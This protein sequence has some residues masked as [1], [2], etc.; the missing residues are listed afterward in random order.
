MRASIASAD[1]RS[2]IGGFEFTEPEFGSYAEQLGFSLSDSVD[3]SMAL[4][5]ERNKILAI[6][7]A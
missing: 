1:L 4:C 5:A 3:L 6:I 2:L 7:P